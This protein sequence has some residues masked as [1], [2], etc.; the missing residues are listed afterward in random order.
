[1]RGHSATVLFGTLLAL[2]T[3]CRPT[4][5]CAETGAV[6]GGDPV[7]RWTEVAA[8][9]DPALLDMTVAKRT[10]RGQPVVTAGQVPPEPTSTDWCADLSYGASGITFLNLPRDP[11]RILGADLTFRSDDPPADTTGSYGALVT[12]SDV[13]SIEFSPT[14]LTRRG[15]ASTDCKQFGD[16]FAL[17][18]T[19]LGGVKE[20]RCQ[21]APSGG[22]LCDYTIESDAA[23]SNLTGR[24]RRAGNVMTFYPSNMVLPTRA[25]YC[26]EADRMTLWGHDRTNLFDLA[27]VRTMSLDRVVC[28]NHVVERGE[29]CD[30]PDPATC[31]ATCQTIAPP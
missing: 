13:T 1:M 15:Y 12:T 21:S 27:G 17:F 19:G 14:C 20:T 7:A 11:P 23:G 18:G 16:A 30:P 2:A 9:Q 5:T 31:S 10:Y 6:C 29:Q 22:C 8:C 28:G 25:D 24:W 3:G 26:I 4:D